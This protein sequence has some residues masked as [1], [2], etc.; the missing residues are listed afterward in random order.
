MLFL[1]LCWKYNAWWLQ[2]SRA[3]KEGVLPFFILFGFVWF[4]YCLATFMSTT[5]HQGIIEYG[6]EII[7][8]TSHPQ[9]E[10]TLRNHFRRFNER[11][12]VV[13]VV[14]VAVAERVEELQRCL[15]DMF[16]LLVLVPDNL[17]LLAATYIYTT[18]FSLDF[19]FFFYTHLLKTAIAWNRERTEDRGSNHVFVSKAP[20]HIFQIAGD[21]VTWSEV[22][23]SLLVRRV[24]DLFG[25]QRHGA[26]KH[27]PGV[28]HLET[29]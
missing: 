3:E 13:V 25:L 28:N 8:R 22:F 6:Q 24:L 7:R 29:P 9:L 17:L 5:E 18:G 11:D 2:S 27:L 19:F 23:K 12:V 21:L 14:V 15:M 1:E 26:L 4:F 10:T 16:L 20:K